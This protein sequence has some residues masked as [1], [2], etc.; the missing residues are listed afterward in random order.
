LRICQANVFGGQNDESTRDKARVLTRLNHAGEIV[1]GCVR[2]TATDGLDESTDYVIVLISPGVIAHERSIDSQ[3]HVF[4]INR[5][6]SPSAGHSRTCFQRGQGLSGISSCYPNQILS[7][8]IVEGK[9][10][11]KPSGISNG[12]IENVPYVVWTQRLQG[13]EQ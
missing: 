6:Y 12:P 9:R 4:R 11:R 7:R 13:D 8:I 1:K 10:S 2:I 3:S 5:G